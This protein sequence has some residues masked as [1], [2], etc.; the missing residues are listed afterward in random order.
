MTPPPEARQDNRIVLLDALRGFALFGIL[1]VNIEWQANGLCTPRGAGGPADLLAEFLRLAVFGGKFYIIFAFLF[2]YGAHLMLAGQ[3]PDGTDRFRRRMLALLLFGLLHFALVSPL[4]ILALYGVAGLVLAR[5]IAWS[6]ERLIRSA[7]IWLAVGSVIGAVGLT[8]AAVDPRYA[9]ASRACL[10]VDRAMRGD[11][12]AALLGARLPGQIAEFA[13]SMLV[14]FPA[15]GAAFMAGL[16]AARRRALRDPRAALP[17]PAGRIAAL[18]L[19]GLLASG[20][21]ALAVQGFWRPR[22]GTA[23]ALSLTALML[24]P[25]V[26]ILLALPVVALARRTAGHPAV[27]LLAAA[28]R[29]SFSHYLLQSFVT[30]LVF[31]GFGLGLYQ[32]TGAAAT[33]LLALA[34]PVALAGLLSL[35]E[36][37]FGQGPAEALMARLVGR[38]SL[39]PPAR[40]A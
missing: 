26:S 36:R 30:L 1:Q 15:V 25:A 33:F 11:S 2:G 27:R 38:K 29:T 6:D 39:P 20:V 16:L 28:G 32:R 4:D 9:E 34:I 21:V 13:A 7:A 12:Y 40:P 22:A 18:A 5:R 37:R 17:L 14:Q 3:G 24:S 31:A 35:W 19:A 10:A 23:F 8:L